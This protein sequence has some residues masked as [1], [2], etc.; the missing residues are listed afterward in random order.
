MELTNWGMK[1]KECLKEIF[2]D[3]PEDTDFGVLKIEDK[4]V[5]YILTD[6]YE[7]TLSFTEPKEKTVIYFD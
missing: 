2:V 4:Y 7:Y 3:L 1:Q 6:D 5:K